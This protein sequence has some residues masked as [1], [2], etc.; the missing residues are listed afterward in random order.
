[1]LMAV[2][3]GEMRKGDM[4]HKRSNVVGGIL[5]V[6]AG[7]VLLLFQFVPG[8]A[9]WVR[10]EWSWPLF[11]VGT[12]LLLLLY[13]IAGNVPDMAV[14]ACIV[15]G[16]GLLLYW[17]NLTGRWE[18]W[19]YAWTLIP[20]FSGV[21]AIIAALLSGKAK[22]LW[23]GVWAIVISAVLFAAFGSFFGGIKA[24]GDWWPVLLILLGVLLLG[25]AIL[26][27]RA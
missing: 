16:I 7:I 24:L 15:G 18:T 19:S 20:G 22:Q 13:A 17:Q 8:L 4:A 9:D 2:F 10:I 25:R 23:E 12:G 3:M 14:P 5:L 27:P 26:R 6:L 11:V 21:G 1:M